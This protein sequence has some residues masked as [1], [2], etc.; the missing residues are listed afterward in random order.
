MSGDVRMKEASKGPKKLKIKIKKTGLL[1][2]GTSPPAGG[3][4]NSVTLSQV[5]AGRVRGEPSADDTTG[6]SVLGG[7]HQVV[8]VDVDIIVIFD[9]V[10]CGLSWDLVDDQARPL[11]A[12]ICDVLHL[13]THE[14]LW[15]LTWL[16][17]C[18]QQVFVLW[19]TDR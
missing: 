14:A 9:V 8:D 1:I 3:K 13:F 7:L 6:Q 10:Y 16:P 15:L 17:V 4:L 5:T 2:F 11:Q 18:W 19:A 12:V